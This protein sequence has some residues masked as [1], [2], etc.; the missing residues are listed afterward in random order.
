M[1]PGTEGIDSG[2]CHEL[3]PDPFGRR[4]AGCCSP[5]QSHDVHDGLGEGVSRVRCN[6]K[7][8]ADGR[9]STTMPAEP[10]W[11]GLSPETA[12]MLVAGACFPS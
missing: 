2:V 7:S 11:R 1:A 9:G 8:K 3:E 4:A 12:A 10:C 5:Q 6:F